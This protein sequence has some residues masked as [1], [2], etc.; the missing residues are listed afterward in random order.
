MARILVIDDEHNLRT[1]IVAFLRARGHTVKEGPSGEA[2]L[3]EY[4]ESPSDVVVLDLMLPGLS[5]LETLT[6]LRRMDPNVTCIVITAH[7]SVPSAVEA[8]RRGAYDYVAK[9]F[10]NDDLLLA[11]ERADEHRRLLARVVELEEDVS[12]RVEFS[13]IVGRSAAIQEVLRRLAKV[14]RS[15]A[16]V[17]LTGE[18]GTGKELAAR[19]LHRNSQRASKAFVAV[20]CGAIP[21]TLAEDE[22]FG[23]VK[24]GFTDARTDR[25]GRF[26][27]A[28]GGTLFL[29][30][31]GDLSADL[32][33]KLLRAIQEH[34]I[35]RIGSEQPLR[36]D[37]R[38]VVATN[39]PLPQDVAAGRFRSDLFW[40]LNVF[41][42]EMPALRKH[43]E[44]LPVLTAYLLDRVNLE[45]RTT[46]E[47]VS[48]EVQTRFE[49]YLWPGNVRE[50]TNV[51]RHGVLMAESTLLQL[52]DLPE[53]IFERAAIAPWP[54]GSSQ[55]LEQAL[56]ETEER[57]VKATLERF[58]GNRSAAA[59]A[60]GID[61]RTLYNKLRQ[62]N[63]TTMD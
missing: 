1:A 51:L 33:V 24:G 56:A 28:H 54:E 53:Y 29:D 2:C 31:V 43:R 5:G 58:Q 15:D 52:Q 21:P 12:A 20:N 46:V 26:E 4:A 9:P 42:I 47:G 14:A 3:K 23:H 32:Q 37:I 59:A 16:T 30:E 22:L 13:G 10:D 62:Y 18:T 41:Q 49:T 27:Q 38:L 39:R 25:R 55:T 44:D 40:R 48:Q 34:E 36:V 60:L 11:V 35:Y 50:L 57:L 6:R 8:M 17:L 7:G 63:Q 45:C 19:N 61:R